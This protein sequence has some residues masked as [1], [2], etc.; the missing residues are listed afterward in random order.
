MVFSS[1]VTFVEFDLTTYALKGF[2][3]C[4]VVFGTAGYFVSVAQNSQMP[5][6]TRSNVE[7]ALYYATR[8][9]SI[10]RK[11]SVITRAKS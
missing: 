1:F 7:S 10:G 4:C 11:R 5:S 2:F 8:L 3:C 9:E 6:E